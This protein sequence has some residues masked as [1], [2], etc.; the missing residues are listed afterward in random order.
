M[1][2]AIGEYYVKVMLNLLKFKINSQLRLYIKTIKEE[3][4]IMI[5][6]FILMMVLCKE[7]ADAD[8]YINNLNH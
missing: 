7:S 6:L 8:E 2:L 1:E 4:S 3:I 5:T